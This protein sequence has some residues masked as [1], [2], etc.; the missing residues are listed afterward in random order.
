[1]IAIPLEIIDVIDLNDRYPVPALKDNATDKQKIIYADFINELIKMV[2]VTT[3]LLI[4]HSSNIN[5]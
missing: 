5:F 3:S 2:H 4:N 1:M